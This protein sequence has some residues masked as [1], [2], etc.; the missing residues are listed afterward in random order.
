MARFKEGDRVRVVSRPTTPEESSETGYYDHMAGL[1]GRI[2]NFY[3]D[4]EI[5]VGV[6][7]E[8]LGEV[9]GKL[10][11]RAAKRMQDKF[12]DSISTEQRKQL[13]NEEIRFV[14]HYMLLVRGSDLEKA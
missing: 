7:L 10:H 13:T 11:R 5:A 14:P 12:L 2:E 9:E 8:C 1:T 4:E 6:D 3:S